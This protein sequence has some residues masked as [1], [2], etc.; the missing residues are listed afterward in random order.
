MSRFQ[1]LPVFQQCYAHSKEIYRLKIQ[2][3]K[4]IK[5]DLGSEVFQSS[6]RCVKLVILAN[7]LQIKEPA[8]KEVLLEVDLQWVYLRMLHDLQ[9]VSSGQFKDLSTRL[10]EI[11][12][13]LSSWRAFDKKE[14]R[15]RGRT[16][17]PLIKSG[18]CSV[19]ANLSTS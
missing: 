13:Q 8:L 17:D 4:A 5:H 18:F 10:A 19:F 12:K 15:S 3:P 2:L 1:H 16:G 14:S 9:V 7:R 11:G 6:I